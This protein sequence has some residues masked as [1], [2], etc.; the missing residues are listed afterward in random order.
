[1]NIEKIIDIYAESINRADVKLAEKIFL[2]SDEITF[3]QPKIY[4]IG[5]KEIKKKIYNKN[6]QVY[7]NSAV[8]VFY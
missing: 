7:G 8:A 5:W 2:T 3:I 4:A 1:M 6:I